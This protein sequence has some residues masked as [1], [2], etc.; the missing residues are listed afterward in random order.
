MVNDNGDVRPQAL[1]LTFFGGHV[2]G[3]GVRVSTGSVLEV[4]ARVGVAEPAARSTLSRMAERGLLRR[5]RIGRKTYLGLTPRAREILADGEVRIWRV[6]VV[7]DHWDG[8]WTLLGFTVPESRRRQR[9]L[10]R[11]RLM[12][13]GFGALRGGLWI[14]PSPVDVPRLLEGIEATEHVTVFQ[15]RALSP[16][17]LRELVHGAWDIEGLAKRHRRFIERWSPPV[18]AEAADPLARQLLLTAEWLQLLRRDPRLPIGHL[19]ADWPAERAQR[20]FRRLHAELDP[21]A[22]VLASGLLDTVPEEDEGPGR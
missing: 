3:R 1:L 19:P 4:L 22:R 11:S 17:D 6:G 14:S 7:N 2:L 15:A 18:E 9:H 8:A 21:E 16:T 10:L 13:A 20:R 12:W 5:H